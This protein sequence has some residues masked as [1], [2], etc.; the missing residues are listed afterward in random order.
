MSAHLALSEPLTPVAI[1]RMTMFFVAGLLLVTGRRGHWLAI[2][3]L[4]IYTIAMGRYFLSHVEPGVAFVIL[5]RVALIGVLLHPGARKALDPEAEETPPPSAWI[6][7]VTW[8]GV[9]M[10]VL[11]P[12]RLLLMVLFG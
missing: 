12:I 10:L 9:T 6:R 8:L 2:I 4:G 5:A 7:S 3:A 11:G 1:V